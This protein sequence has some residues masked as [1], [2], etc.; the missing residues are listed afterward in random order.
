MDGMTLSL[1]L[2][3]FAE[4]ALAAGRYGDLV[5]VVAAGLSLLCQESERAA[6]V[7][8]LEEAEAESE[9]EGF[10]CGW[11]VGLCLSSQQ[12]RPS[13]NACPGHGV[14]ALVWMHERAYGQAERALLQPPSD[15]D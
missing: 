4:A 1:E 8:S 13:P 14:I 9:R 2:A 10:S 5:E 11:T 7:G 3:R 12:E 15:V 6:S